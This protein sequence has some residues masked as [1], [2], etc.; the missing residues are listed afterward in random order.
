MSGNSPGGTVRDA[1]SRLASVW[2]EVAR[3]WQDEVAKRFLDEFWEPLVEAIDLYR[4][5][6]EEL[7]AALAEAESDERL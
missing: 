3:E 1:G 4:M 7:E 5:A 6:L 2:A